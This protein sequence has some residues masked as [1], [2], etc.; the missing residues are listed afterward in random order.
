MSESQ[1]E[2][3]IMP[4]EP[5]TRIEAGEGAEMPSELE[6]ELNRVEGQDVGAPG[7]EAHPNPP[8]AGAPAEDEGPLGEGGQLRGPDAGGGSGF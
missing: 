7:Q 6:S 2:N 5:P 3:P 8:V 1:A 4:D